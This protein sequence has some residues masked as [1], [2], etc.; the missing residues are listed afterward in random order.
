MAADE[1]AA[2]R[3]STGNQRRTTID[4]QAADDDQDDQPSLTGT[5]R[6]MR[7]LWMLDHALS[8]RSKAMASATGI[9]GPQRLVLRVV[10]KNPGISAG[11]VARTLHLDKSTISGVLQRLEERGLLVRRADPRDARR[12]RLHLTAAGAEINRSSAGTIE[13]TVRRALRRAPVSQRQAA[14]ALLQDLAAALSDED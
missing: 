5:L 8:R 14:E 11:T 9:T 6:F 7:V 1:A 4:R 3:M 10:G 2:T 12:V 13:A